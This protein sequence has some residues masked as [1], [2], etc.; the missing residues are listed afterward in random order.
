MKTTARRYDPSH[1]YDR[2]GAFLVRTYRT[3][4]APINWLQTRWEYMHYHSNINSVDSR[5]FGIWE[6][7]GEIVAV[8]HAEHD[9]GTAYFQTDPAHPDLN[10]EMLAHAEQHLYASTTRG[11]TLSVYVDD[12]D[13]ALQAVAGAAGYQ[14]RSSGEQMSRL[15]LPSGTSAAPLPDGFRLK[16]LTTEDEMRRLHRLLYRGFG[17]GHEPTDHGV[18]ARR[19]M[20][21]APNYD[22][23]LHI[24]A[25]A[26]DGDFA[27]YC[28]TWHETHNHFAYIEPVATDPSYRRLGL[29]AAVVLEGVR[30]CASR[31][32]TVAYVGATLPVYLSLGFRQTFGSRAWSREWAADEQALPSTR[33]DTLRRGSGSPPC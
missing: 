4:G 32:A 10:H 5:A 13:A 12:R 15:A 21:S 6:N 20:Q 19:F 23:S 2:V 8:A 11:R 25:E 18:A 28:G 30:R 7:D 17:H 16:T 33:S 27:S 24:V 26:P 14:R 3:A 22:A 31:G 1:D 9:R 29:A